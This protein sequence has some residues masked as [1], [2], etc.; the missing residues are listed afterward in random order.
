MS[1]PM[2][3]NASESAVLIADTPEG[4]VVQS[5]VCGSSGRD[6]DDLG[7]GEL[8]AS[9]QEKNEQQRRIAR[10][11]ERNACVFFKIEVSSEL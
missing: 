11:K 5:S 10:S 6:E 3:E 9:A 2:R 8:G 4:E 7:G 1:V